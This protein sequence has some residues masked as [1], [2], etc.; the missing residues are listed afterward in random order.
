MDHLPFDGIVFYMQCQRERNGHI[1]NLGP[2]FG[3]CDSECNW[4]IVVKYEQSI[5]SFD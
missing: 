1:E 5:C 4:Y 2:Y 3:K